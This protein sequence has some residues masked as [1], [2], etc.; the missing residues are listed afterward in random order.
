MLKLILK[1]QRVILEALRDGTDTEWITKEIDKQIEAT[2]EELSK[3]NEK[4]VFELEQKIKNLKEFIREKADLDTA[5]YLE[6]QIRE[7]CGNIY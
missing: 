3:S 1:N 6:Q 4:K 5:N 7:I 2:S